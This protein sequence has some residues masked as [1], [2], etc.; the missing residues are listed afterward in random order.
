LL[1][2]PSYATLKH[3]HRF[4]PAPPNPTDWLTERTCYTSLLTSL[5]SRTQIFSTSLG[6]EADTIILF[7]SSDGKFSSRHCSTLQWDSYEQP[8]C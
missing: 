6:H 7:W 4:W 2:A 3:Q 8:A 1:T 5:H